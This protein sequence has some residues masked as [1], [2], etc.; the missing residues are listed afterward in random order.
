MWGR[1]RLAEREDGGGGGGQKEEE[2]RDGASEGGD[3]EGGRV[4]GGGAGGAGGAGAGAGGLKGPGGELWKGSDLPP[5]QEMGQLSVQVTIVPNHPYIGV[6]GL[7]G[8][9]EEI[10]CEITGEKV[11]TCRGKGGC[12]FY[13]KVGLFQ[14]ICF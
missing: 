3:G 6:D 10:I 2:I 11:P 14:K 13:T 7:D 12:C 5:H 1:V 9:G 8:R 4:S